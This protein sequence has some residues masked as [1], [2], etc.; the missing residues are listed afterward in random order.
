MPIRWCS[1]GVLQWPQPPPPTC[2]GRQ[3]HR[4]CIKPFSLLAVTI[5]SFL[6]SEPHIDHYRHTS[7]KLQ[8]T[9][10][11][12]GRKNAHIQIWT[13]IKMETWKYFAYFYLAT[14]LRPLLL[15]LLLYKL[16]ENVGHLFALFDVTLILF[17]I[18]TKLMPINFR[19]NQCNV[20]VFIFFTSLLFPFCSNKFALAACHWNSRM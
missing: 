14:F 15:L 19:L 9:S 6:G 17:V 1:F 18:P 3:P 8:T 2:N 7:S 10:R 12:G 13:Q 11:S 5:W 20:S 4:Y 16:F